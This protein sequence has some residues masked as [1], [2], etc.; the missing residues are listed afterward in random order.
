MNKILVLEPLHSTVIAKV[1]LPEG[2]KLTIGRTRSSEYQVPFDNFMSSVHFELEHASSEARILDRE[3]RN[4]TYV[5]GVKVR[6]TSLRDGDQITAGMTVFAV[7]LVDRENGSHQPQTKSCLPA[8]RRSNLLSCLNPFRNRHLC[9]P[10]LAHT[11]ILRGS[12][13]FR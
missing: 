7:H 6:A 9:T 3:S 12:P 11:M 4:G 13:Y 1:S 8:Q 2:Q 5:N 10:E